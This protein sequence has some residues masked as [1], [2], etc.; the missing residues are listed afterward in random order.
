MNGIQR[1]FL[2]LL[3]GMSPSRRLRIPQN[4]R[5]SSMS[6]LRGSKQKQQISRTRPSANE[7]SMTDGGEETFTLMPKKAQLHRQVMWK[8]TVRTMRWAETT[9]LQVQ[10]QSWTQDASH[11]DLGHRQRSASRTSSL[12]R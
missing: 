1:M 7:P 12:R 2:M 3:V 6:N 11:S 10:T 5:E 9:A 8:P 4:E